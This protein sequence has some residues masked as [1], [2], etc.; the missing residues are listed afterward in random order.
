VAVAR[1]CPL[2]RGLL[3]TEGPAACICDEVDARFPAADLKAEEWEAL[4]HDAVT[5]SGGCCELRIPG[6]CLGAP[7][8]RKGALPGALGTAPWSLHHRQP[9][10]MGGASRRAV[11]NLSTLVVACGHG[12]A[13]CHGWVEHH[14]AEGRARRLLVP[15]GIDATAEPL[16]LQGGQVVGLDPV[17]PLYLPPPP[18]WPPWVW[19]DMPE[20]WANDTP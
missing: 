20:W 18:G 19:D 3:D 13:G 15:Q 4:R 5:R 6:V 16:I 12:T 9:R 8:S 2:C 14:R 1:R 11:H 17:A 7:R 10:G